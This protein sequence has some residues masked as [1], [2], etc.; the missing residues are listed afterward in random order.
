[1]DE[2]RMPEA[3]GNAPAAGAAAP[4]WTGRDR[5]GLGLGL[6]LAIL[7]LRVFGLKYMD[8]LPALGAAA[9]VYALFAA[10]L[11]TLGKRTARSGEA[12]VLT[13]YTLLLSLTFA[14]Y[15]PDALRPLHCLAALLTGAMAVFALAGHSR[16]SWREWRVLPDTAALS[17]RAL[18]GSVF[19]PFRALAA[20]DG[21]GKKRLGGVAAGAL[22]LLPLLAAVLALLGSADPVFAALFTPLQGWLRW[23]TAGQD[24][25]WALRALLWGLLLCSALHS[26]SLPAR[27]RPEPA[28]R[29]R[30]PFTL[31]CA[32]VLGGLD[33]VYAVFV[34]VQFACLFGGAETAAMKGGYAAYARSGFFQLAAVA[35]INAAAALAAGEASA[36]AARRGRRTLRILGAALLALTAVILA[37]AVCRM[38]LYI[39][40]YG[41]SLLRVLTLWGMA[42]V[43]VCLV[44]AGLRLFRPGFRF[45]ALFFAAALAGWLLLAA[46]NPAARIAAWNVDAYLDGRVEQ[47]DY[48]YLASL[49]P[50]A[51]P[52]LARLEAAEGPDFRAA[53]EDGAPAA[54]SLGE[55]VAA[56]RAQDG[57]TWREWSLTAALRRQAETAG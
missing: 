49:S 9:F 11:L 27:P 17:A 48:E 38:A 25:W 20:L 5:L 54:R 21:P 2:R 46:L 30:R 36:L 29:P 39:S 53:G 28:A 43:A 31:P 13:G 32:V 34:A 35:A 7:F 57:G 16:Y 55:A 24:L 50:D 40:V 51:L 23:E 14:L 18:F 26:L 22:I 44:G 52:A 6:A 45:F 33:A 10:V 12:A 15:A 1:M 56:L 47:I 3:T 37:S 4:R 8:S 41:L 19:R 42:F